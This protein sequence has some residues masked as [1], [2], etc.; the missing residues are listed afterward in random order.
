MANKKSVYS[1]P[2][3]LCMSSYLYMCV[4]D[5]LFYTFINPLCGQ[6]VIRPLDNWDNISSRMETCLADIS[7]WMCLNLLKLNQDK[8]NFVYTKNS[9]QGIFELSSVS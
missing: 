3:G 9:C 6:L 4:S 8:T 5:I 1:H 2:D 7:K